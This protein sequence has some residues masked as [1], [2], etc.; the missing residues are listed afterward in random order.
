MVGHCR[1][2]ISKS[3]EEKCKKKLQNPSAC[4]GTLWL[5]GVFIDWGMS[6]MA[7][8]MSFGQLQTLVQ[9]DDQLAPAVHDLCCLVRSSGVGV[10][11]LPEVVIVKKV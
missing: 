3:N 11:N 2:V 9:R 10:F 8:E 6:V 4:P 7:G 5:S 1:D